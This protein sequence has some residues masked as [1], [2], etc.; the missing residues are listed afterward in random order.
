VP[1]PERVALDRRKFVVGAAAAVAGAGLST[2]ARPSS[3]FA[4][5]SLVGKHRVFP[6]PS[7]IP[8]GAFDVG[9]PLGLI[10][11]FVPGDPSVTLPFSGGTP[12]GFDVEPGTI[13]DFN[14]SSAVAFHVGTARG[15]DG[16]TYNL[17]TDIRTFKGSYVVDGVTHQGSFG[18]V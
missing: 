8:G 13:T 18:F 4:A 16:K 11:V 1:I 15:S 12:Q 7:P 3:A 6:P 2:L 17:E 10:H 14:G 9:P 5:P